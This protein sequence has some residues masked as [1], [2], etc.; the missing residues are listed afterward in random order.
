[1]YYFIL[2]KFLEKS[3]SNKSGDIS[4]AEFIH[5]VKEHEKNLRLSFSH[6]DKNK[7]GKLAAK[8]YHL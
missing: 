6:I 5:Y 7:D 4:L 3:D 2:Q 8:Y 1:M